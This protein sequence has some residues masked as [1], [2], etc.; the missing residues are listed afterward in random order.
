MLA[1]LKKKSWPKVT[2]QPR[3]MMSSQLLRS[4]TLDY[5]MRSEDKREE[6]ANKKKTLTIQVR[7]GDITEEQVD[8]IVNAA[9]GSLRH[10]GGLAAAIVRRGGNEIQ[11][12]SD[13]YVNENGVIPT[14]RVGVTGPGAL[15]CKWIIHAVGP[16]WKGV[17]LKQVDR[18]GPQ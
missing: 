1:V 9:N 11:R 8:A 16:V 7:M 2:N 13:R 12:E 17:R 3:F 15:P 18:V 5:E 4:V 10:G 14:G 6:N